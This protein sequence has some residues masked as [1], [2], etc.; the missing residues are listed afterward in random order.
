[1]LFLRQA[2]ALGHVFVQAWKRCLRREKGHLQSLGPE[3]GGDMLRKGR[4]WEQMSGV[5]RADSSSAYLW[6]KP[7]R[8][9]Q[10]S[11]ATAVLSPVDCAPPHLLLN[12]LG[13]VSAAASDFSQ[14]C[15]HGFPC[16]GKLLTCSSNAVAAATGESLESAAS[17]VRKGS[18]ALGTSFPAISGVMKNIPPPSESLHVIW[19]DFPLVPWPFTSACPDN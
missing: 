19:S 5:S 8:A 14:Q 16:W 2:G 10:H 13:D 9:E 6:R 17:G 18:C 3:L 1:M 7:R 12:S 15:L 4:R 11:T